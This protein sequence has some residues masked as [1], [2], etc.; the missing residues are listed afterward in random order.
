[1]PYRW[2]FKFTSSRSSVEN[3]QRAEDA[4]APYLSAWTFELLSTRNWG[5]TPESILS[6]LK[7]IKR[8]IERQNLAEGRPKRGDMEAWVTDLKTKLK[9]EDELAGER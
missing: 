1:M 7:K 8:Q 4:M 5:H 2:G 6:L 3:L 9:A